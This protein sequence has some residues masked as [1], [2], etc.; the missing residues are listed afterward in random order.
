M[1]VI[2]EKYNKDWLYC[3]PKASFERISVAAFE[4]RS[5][6]FMQ[7]SSIYASRGGVK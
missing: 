2:T 6:R 1:T 3:R 7:P 4:G 5:G